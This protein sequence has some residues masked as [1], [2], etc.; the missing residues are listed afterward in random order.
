MGA[1]NDRPGGYDYPERVRFEIQE[2]E[3][4]S[5]RRGAD[6]LNLNDIDVLCVQHE[7][8]IF[9]GEAGRHLLTLLDEVRMPVVTTFHTLL[10]K[11]TKAQAEVMKQLVERS[12][13]LVVMAEK[14]A[15]ILSEHHPQAVEKLDVIPHG[16]PDVPF[17]ESEPFKA[18][19]GVE[20]RPVLLTFGLI[21]PGKGIEQVIEALPAIV[22]AH[23]ETVYIVLGATHPHLLEQEGERYR[24][25]LK[26]LAAERGVKSHVIF[27]NHFVTQDELQEFIGAAD[28][29]VTPYLNAAQITS[30][31][32]AYAVGAGKAVVSTPYWHAE[33]LLADG[34]GVLVPYRDPGAIA[35]AVCGLFE[36]KQGMEE[37]RKAAYAHGREMTWPAVGSRYLEV[38]QGV[39]SEPRR[40]S[41]VAFAEWTLDARP[42]TLPPRRLDHILRLTDDTGLFQ[43]AIFNVPK[44]AE[45]YCTDDNARAYVLCTWLDTL[46]DNSL[47]RSLPALSTRYLAFVAA[48]FNGEQGRFRNFMSYDREWLEKTGSEDCHGR[49]LWAAG[50]GAGLARDEGHRKLAVQLFECGLPVV[51]SLTSPRAWAFT[52]IG[53][54]AFR[55]RERLGKEVRAVREELTR[56]MVEL[57]HDSATSDWRWFERSLTYENARLSQAMILSGHQSSSP[58]VLD[59]G[60]ESL[61]WFAE[62]QTAPSGCFRPIGSNGFYVRGGPRADYDQQPVEAQAMVAACHDAFRVTGDRFWQEEGRRAFEW[63]LGR[64]DLGTPLYDFTTGGCADGLHSDRVN[65]NQGAESTLAF[66]LALAD[67]RNAEHFVAHPSRVAAVPLKTLQ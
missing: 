67:M 23:P 27:H 60:L 1:I 34:R 53:I 41:R 14:G 6:F 13:R 7:F 5:Y 62:T 21:G 38:F 4:D 22:R 15:E 49:A 32:L 28:V 31:T 47:L 19:F 29:Y 17:L 8:G 18:R 59:L 3:L 25:S 55:R 24:L 43:H 44:F 54:H 12:A 36:D 40:T 33:E 2:T 63:F 52:L 39:C 56:R 35:E 11:P 10:E 26:F 42:P 66:H 30:G 61:R 51:P 58:E 46:G 65:E 16:I 48:A 9:G 45:G 64:N 37:I 20:G 50:I 57:F